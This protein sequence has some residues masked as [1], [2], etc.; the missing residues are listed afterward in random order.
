MPKNSRQSQ[1]QNSQCFNFHFC[2]L[3]LIQN[4]LGVRVLGERLSWSTELPACPSHG[5][6]Y[7]GDVRLRFF[8]ALGRPRLLLLCL[9]C[10]SLLRHDHDA[11]VR[12]FAL[13]AGF[14]CL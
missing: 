12:P 13:V 1:G 5:V 3:P 10:A 14:V 6:G 9:L 4:A 8:P 2:F 11:Q 7:R